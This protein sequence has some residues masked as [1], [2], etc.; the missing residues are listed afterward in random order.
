A[1]L[2]KQRFDSDRRHGKLDNSFKVSSSGLVPYC[3]V[4]LL[5]VESLQY[6]IFLSFRDKYLNQTHN[7]NT[8]SGYIIIIEGEIKQAAARS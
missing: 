4:N 7:K 1:Q 5:A 3:V 6:R 2:F 8:F